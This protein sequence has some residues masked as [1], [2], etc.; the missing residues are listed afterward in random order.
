MLRLAK[1]LSCLLV[2]SLA[3]PM[4]AQTWL[5]LKEQGANYNQIR[6]AFYRQNASKL[7]NFKKELKKEA[8]GKAADAGKYER[9]MEGMVHFMRW[10]S[11]VEPRVS[12]LRGDMSAMNEGMYRAIQQKSREV[13]SRAANWTL[14][15]PQSIPTN[16]G[17]GRVNAVRV[18][19][20]DPNTLFACT[21][22]SGLWKSTNGGTSWTAISDAISALGCT[23]IAFDPTN[24]NTM[25]LVTG[26]GDAADVLTLGVYKSTD[27]GAT[28]NPTSLVFSLSNGQTLSKILVSPTNANTIIVGGRAGIYRSTDA[29]ATWTQTMTGGVRD[30][31]FKSGDPSVVFAGGYGTN[32]G[33][34][35]STDGGVTF[36]KITTVPSTA[37]QRVAI[38]VTAANA[39]YV[40]A[41]VANDGATSTTAYGLKGVYQSIDGGTTFT[42]MSGTTNTLGWY[43][44]TTGDKDGQGWY[45]LAIAVSPTSATTVTTGGVNIWQSTNGGTAWTKKTAWDASHTA[46]NYVHADIHD[47]TYSGATLYAACDGGVFKS[48]NGGTSWTDISANIS[49]AQLYGLGLSASS[50]TTIISGHQDNGTNLT[51]NGT[52]WSQ[53]NGGDGMLCFIDRTNNANQFSSIY[54]GNLYRSTNSGGSFSAIYTVPGG[55]WV[56]PWLQDP[57]T[58]TTLYAGGSNI[59]RSTNSGTAWSAI[60]SLTAPSGNFL[61]FVSISVAKTNN[62]VIYASADAKSSTTGAWSS[63]IIYKT[64]VG[65]TTWTNISAGLPAAAITSV[66]VDVNDANKVYVSLASYSGNSVYLTT[67]GGTTWTNIS[68]GLPQIPANCFVTQNSAAGVVYCGTDLGVYFSSNS[69]TT[70]ESFTS[71]M[72]G[73]IVKDLE[74]YYPTNRIRAATYGRGIWD[75]NLNGVNSSPSVSITS[76]TTGSVFATPATVTIN[77]TATDADGSV[78]NVEFY[79]GATLLGSDNTSP[80]SYTWSGV[81]VGSYAITA[82]AYDNLGASTTS[83][84]VNISVSVANDAG[85]SAIAT[86]NGSVSTATVTPSVTL[87][88]FGSATLTSA[89]IL[90]KVDAGTETTYNWTG[91]LASAGTVSVTLPSVTGYTSGSHTFTA[92]TTNPNATTDGNTANDATTSNFTYSTCSNTNETANNSSTTATVMAVNT[93]QSSQIGSA[94]DVDYYKFTTTT[95]APKIR[96]TLTNLPADYDVTLYKAKAN[97][98]IGA[99]AAIS[100]NTGTTSETITYNTPTAGATYYIKVVGFSGAFS[101]TQCY[102]L[103]LNTSSTNFIIPFESISRNEKGLTQQ[104]ALSV[105]PNPANDFTTVLF[106]A[107]E[108][109]EYT[110]RL[111]DISGKELVNRIQSF[112][113][114]ENTVQLK[115]ND[116]PKGVFLVHVSNASQSEVSKLIIER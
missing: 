23:D 86:P 17:N 66:H 7:K 16:G 97:G 20:T 70:W 109:G 101:T 98:T 80:Y 92:R 113:I 46:T 52:S 102:N 87:K 54:N 116:L 51:T 32:V 78:S 111:T 59:Y 58:A 1:M 76:P 4:N 25:Y 14:M 112:N 38:G 33:F 31:E 60:S 93:T 95:A 22:A 21:P 30:L 34:W 40:Y 6:D 72:P 36:T 15:G 96:I 48:T 37:A 90:Y 107:E 85:I 45:D 110:L 94:T 84:V 18:H 5:D 67:N 28:W 77:A 29:G 11:F 65:G 115:T 55:G 13:S 74:I 49:N 57:V 71:G 68:A 50:A 91:S 75:S 47:L 73:I 12:E 8:N 82:K 53:V 81:T 27:G 56:T 63:S 62:Q 114:G 64:T 83:T 88:N 61:E 69:G 35:R 89:S 3:S 2:I 26:D 104:M 41:L 105:Y 79:N 106:T 99:Q 43:T 44:G 19:P 9:E 39:N 24:P 103:A 10:S 100:Q 108:A 42:L